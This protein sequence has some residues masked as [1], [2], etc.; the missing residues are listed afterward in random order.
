[1]VTALWTT[2]VASNNEY[3]PL[4]VVESGELTDVAGAA[5]DG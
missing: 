4:D 2:N 1:M 5:V 3:Q